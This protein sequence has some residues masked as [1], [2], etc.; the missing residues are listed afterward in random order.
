MLFDHHN[1]DLLYAAMSIYLVA[2][3]KKN[4]FPAFTFPGFNKP[5]SSTVD[6]PI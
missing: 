5:F 4:P 2:V 1:R 3:E 6:S